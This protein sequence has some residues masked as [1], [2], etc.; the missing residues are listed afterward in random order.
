MPLAKDGVALFEID[1]FEPPVRTPF[2]LVGCVC[3]LEVD[4][5]HRAQVASDDNGLL[6]VGSGQL[7]LGCGVSSHVRSVL[8]VWKG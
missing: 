1:P 7:V 5:Y 4:S 8:I 2:T 6:A 3:A